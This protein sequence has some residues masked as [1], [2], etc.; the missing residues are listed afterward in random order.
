MSS[1]QSTDL[2]HAGAGSSGN[3]GNSGNDGNSGNGRYG[4]TEE[5]D[6]Y[7]FD[8]LLI[9]NWVREG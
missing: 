6:Y 9:P 2:P 5:I 4:G 1:S 3:G 7:R 8:Y